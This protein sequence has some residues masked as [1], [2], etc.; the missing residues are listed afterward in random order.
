MI[1]PI[2]QIKTAQ[3]YHICITEKGKRFIR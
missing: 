1:E 3:T 2:L